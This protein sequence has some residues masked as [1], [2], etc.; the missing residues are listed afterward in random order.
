MLNGNSG[1]FP[2]KNKKIHPLSLQFKRISFNI[3]DLYFNFEIYQHWN[4]RKWEPFQELKESQ[5]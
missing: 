4:L 1:I 3:S 2:Q 5:I